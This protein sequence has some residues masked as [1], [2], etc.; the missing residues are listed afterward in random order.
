[1]NIFNLAYNDDLKRLKKEK[2]KIN[3]K[4]KNGNTLLHHAIFGG[5]ITTATYLL[6]NGANPNIENNLGEPPLFDCVKRLR[7]N[8]AKLLILNNANPNISNNYNE[9]PL[10]IACSRGN[11]DMVKLLIDSGSV[12]NKRTLDDKLPIHYA[13]LGG[14]KD[15]IPYLVKVMKISYLVKDEY[16]NTLLHYAART[17][18]IEIV[19][20]LVKQKIDINSLNDQFETPLFNAIKNGNLDITKYLIKEGALLDIK[21][22]RYEDIFDLAL[23]HNK[24]DI[25]EFLDDYKMTVEYEELLKE[26]ELILAVLNRDYRLLREL[27]EKHAP[28]NKNKQGYSAIDYAKKYNF[29]LAENILKNI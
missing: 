22:R 2:F 12:I 28:I 23:I 11:I 14:H 19:K 8:C 20:Y 15:L 29:K 25:K 5:A 7:I 27:L 16:G 26:N 4:D 9:L 18:N 17:H 21:N 13:I 3:G 10:H 24:N 6:L 1:M